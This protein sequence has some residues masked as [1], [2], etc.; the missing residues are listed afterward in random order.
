MRRRLN[1]SL[2]SLVVLC[3]FAS[4]AARAQ[5][6]S[7]SSSQ[8]KKKT[9]QA[10]K[11]PAASAKKK[12]AT[13]TPAA[14]ASVA[15]ASDENAA[16]G[17]SPATSDA[18]PTQTPSNT[19]AQKKSEGEA[20]KSEAT[21]SEAATQSKA[22]AANKSVKPQAA[23]G[24]KK[25]A[26][27]PVRVFD[28][29]KAAELKARLVEIDKLP[30]W[31][32]IAELQDFL[33]LDL[34]DD[35]ADRALEHLVSAQAAYGD[36]RLKA[37]DASRGI[38]L[39]RDAVAN[40]DEDVSDRLFYEVVSQLPANLVLRGQTEE[41]FDLARKIEKLARGDAKRLLALAAF[42]VSA[43]QPDDAARVSAA[44]VKLA[45]DLAAAHQGLAAANRLSLKLEESAAEYARAAELDP[46]SEA[47]RSSLA[48]LRRATGKPE[49]ALAI[50]RELLTADP[51]NRG[52]RGGIVL[53]LFAAGR[54]D[55]AEREMEAALKDD[56][57]NIQLLAGAAYWYVAHGDQ[58]RALDLAGRVM[59]IEPRH[60]WAQVALSRALIAN[61]MPFDAERVMRF[62]R[63]YARFPTLDYELANALAAA[64][65]YSEAAEELAHTFTMKGDQIETRLAGRTPST[66]PD[67]IT[68]LAPERRASFFEHDAADTPENARQLK[69]L[70]ALQ[71]SLRATETEEQRA[72]VESSAAQ[73][74]RDFAAGDDAARAFRQLYA[75]NRLLRRNVA[76]T[77]AL[78]LV[79]AAR[80]GVEDAIVTPQA[81]AAV[82]ADELRSSRAASIAQGS[83]PDIPSVPRDVLERLMRGRIEELTGWALLNQGH[84]K[85]AVAP[86][87]QAVGV[88]PENS[89]YWRNALWRLGNAYAASGEPQ[90]ALNTYIKSF[91]QDD[92][93]ETRFAV[94]QSLY[95][96][97][98]GNL[99]GLDVLFGIAPSQSSST[100]AQQT[101]SVAPANP[102]AIDATKLA[103]PL[104]DQAATSDTTKG[105]TKTDEAKRVDAKDTESKDAATKNDEPKNN[106][107]K[108]VE[109]KSPENVPPASS[110]VKAT[111]TPA[112]PTPSPTAT[113]GGP[114][115][116]A[117]PLP[118]TP[119][120]QK[121]ADESP[122]KTSTTPK[123]AGDQGT[124][125]GHAG[126]CALTLNTESVSLEGGAS[127]SIVAAVEGGGDLS[128][129]T[130]TTPNWSDIIVLRESANADAGAVKFTITSI[131]KSSGS[132]VVTI[133]SPCGAKKLTVTVK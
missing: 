48:D 24:Q 57:Q 111:A 62:V 97:L 124:T 72:S 126:E 10:T 70:L 20:A 76:T 2:C 129:I 52:A 8:P 75:A 46:K 21:K 12:P 36:E 17:Q 56:P 87:K 29:A 123:T 9:T 133:K 1:T 33:A 63:L 80:K 79:A 132:Y 15:P 43:E 125:A 68:L 51:T 95:R 105:Q 32:R 98:N 122:A 55:E 45:P 71:L 39:F 69:G 3:T 90:Q 11:K 13:Q 18:A 114:P 67:F 84:A 7:Q 116:T 103:D 14:D 102:R 16:K 121:K 128:K 73:A 28:P 110:D 118:E 44:A 27:A 22:G 54:R 53:S 58:K 30:A 37:G 25:N 65:F 31:E 107:A 77:T 113:P 6:A 60:P 85:D 49:D 91:N 106:D 50:Y 47:A 82:T 120:E 112:T 115:A 64:G 59:Q 94:I 88:L 96:K 130:A 74:A 4:V 100:T 86:L 93:D 119:T 34:P 109:T 108:T 35:L 101:A 89:F 127:V 78:E 81:T 42:Y 26:D 5:D 19:D 66:A 38:A 23:K 117:T 131:S 83:T 99:N 61:Q 41:A 40:A 92:P 104:S